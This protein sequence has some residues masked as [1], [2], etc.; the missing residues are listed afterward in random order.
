MDLLQAVF[1]HLV[2]PPR[3]PGSQDPDIEAVSYD[4]LTRIIRASDTLDSLVGPPWSKA[5]QSLRASFEACLPLHSG[6][7]DKSVLLAYF[8][9]LQ[10]DQMLILHVAE[11]NAALLIRRTKQSVYN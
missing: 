1:N 8:R 6:R 7:L 9:E 3:L 11:Q 2:L 4:V 10:P 5:Y